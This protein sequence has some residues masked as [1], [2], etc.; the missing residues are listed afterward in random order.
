MVVI[1]DYGVG[2]LMAIQNIIKKVGGKSTISSDSKII[3]SAE[4]LILP[5]VGSFDYCAAQLQHRNLIPILEE[6]VF[7]NNKYILGLCVG[8]QLMTKESEEGNLAGLGWVRASTR[9]FDRTRVPVIPHM[10]WADVAF[11]RSGLT[12][13]L[14]SDARFYFVHSYHFVFEDQG[15]VLGTAKFGYEFA[16]AFQRDNIFGVQFHPE[17]SHRYGMRMFKNFI[18]L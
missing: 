5:G 17:K 9:R 16:C 15:Q 14:D 18:S 1:V 3:K 8:A 10:G 12:K 7:V 13:D 11:G 2:N 4:K 6:E